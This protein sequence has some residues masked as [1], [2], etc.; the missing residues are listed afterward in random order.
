MI[1]R[2]EYVKEL[3]RKYLEGTATPIELARWAAAR[4]IYTDQEIISMTAEILEESAK[5]VTEEE[6]AEE[7]TRSAELF[8]QINQHEA[9]SH[10]RTR[11]RVAV[12]IATMVLLA[13]ILFMIMKMGNERMTGAACAGENLHEKIPTAIFYCQLALGKNSLLRIDSATKGIIATAGNI[14]VLQNIPGTLEIHSTP[15]PGSTDSNEAAI[16]QVSTKPGQQYL[17]LLPDKT[18]IRLNA[19]SCVRLPVSGDYTDTLPTIELGGEA[20]IEMIAGHRKPITIK[21]ADAMVC[22]SNAAF[23]I[24]ASERFTTATVIR[25]Q[26]Q[27]CNEMGKSVTLCCRGDKGYYVE[28]VQSDNHCRDTMAVMRH[29]DTEQELM[30]MNPQ[31]RYSRIK[32]RSF[33]AEMSRWYGFTI[34]NMNCIPEDLRISASICYRAPVQDVYT[35]FRKAGVNVYEERGVISFCDPAQ[36]KTNGIRDTRLISRVH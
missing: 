28:F 8:E 25:G 16:L 22:A 33:A 7:T 24:S 1:Q 10:W 31:R 21:T 23:N 2:P 27:L 12:I 36:N 17:V 6:I 26:L 14:T 4:Y 9:S 5:T 34:E 13:G 32:L 11:N 30:W 20:C 15:S 3:L 29:R 19:S 35:V 18:C